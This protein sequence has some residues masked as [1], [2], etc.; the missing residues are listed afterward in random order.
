MLHKVVKQSEDY[1]LSK[2]DELTLSNF[3]I[4]KEG[5]AHG[6]DRLWKKQNIS[7]S[8]YLQSYSSETS[9]PE[10]PYY[11]GMLLELVADM[12]RSVV[13]G[14]AGASYRDMLM[15]WAC[16]LHHL[17]VTNFIVC[18]LDHET[19][20]FS[21]LQV[22]IF[23]HLIFSPSLCYLTF[24]ILCKTT[25]H[26]KLLIGILGFACFHRSIITKECQH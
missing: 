13:L 8:G 12:N 24:F 25:D 21:I 26:L 10:L 3:F 20:E 7:L 23:S 22:I 1:M 19:Y 2:V 9:A 15:S 18:A 6:G 16:R 5:N 11:L 4:S 17:R 14:V